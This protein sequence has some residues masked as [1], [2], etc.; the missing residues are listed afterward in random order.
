MDD[1]FLARMGSMQFQCQPQ[2][3]G[4]L[5]DAGYTIFKYVQVELTADE[6]NRIRKQEEQVEA[7]Q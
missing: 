7:H 4:P 2:L 1:L 5:S 6:I 3:V